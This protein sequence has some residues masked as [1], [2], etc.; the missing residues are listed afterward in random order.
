LLPNHFH[1]LLRSGNTPIAYRGEAIAAA[2]DHE[3]VAGVTHKNR[4]VIYYT[5]PYI[6]YS[7]LGRKAVSWLDAMAVSN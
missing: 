3:P 4:G 5:V 6:L 2:N 7:D 1:L